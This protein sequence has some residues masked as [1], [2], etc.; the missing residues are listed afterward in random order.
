LS[1]KL[2]GNLQE[3]KPEVQGGPDACGQ[4]DTAL[5]S[6]RRDIVIIIAAVRTVEEYLR[7]RAVVAALRPERCGA[8]G[9]TGMWHGNGWYPRGVVWI[10]GTAEALEVRRLECQDCGHTTSLLPD[11]LHRYRHYGL[12]V[13][14][15]V[16]TA[17][18]EDGVSWS[19]LGQAYSRAGAPSLRTMRRWCGAFVQQALAWLTALL[20]AL[21]LVLPLLQ[22]LDAHTAALAVARQVLVLG[23]RLANWLG[24]PTMERS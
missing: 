1:G 5:D 3:D 23:P 13:I 12:E 11:F 17:R 8:C 14:E 16:L 9:S 15:Q 22:A 6:K 4:F 7:Q 20:R 21:A 19:K 18:V 10:G 24:K 2:G